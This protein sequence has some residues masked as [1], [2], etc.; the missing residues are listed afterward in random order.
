MEGEVERNTIP[1]TNTPLKRKHETY[2]YMLYSICM[3][4]NLIYSSIIEYNVIYIYTNS[5]H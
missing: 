1:H 2:K 4:S 3:S 5:L